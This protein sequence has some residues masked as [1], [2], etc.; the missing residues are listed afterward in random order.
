MLLM[1]GKNIRGGI[2]HVIHQYAKANEKYMKDYDKNEKPSYLKYWNINNLYGWVISQKFPVNDFKWVEDI[3]EFNE[4]FM[5]SYNDDSDE[6]Y[7]LEIDVKYPENLHNFHN[8]LP[9]LRKKIEKVEKLK[10]A[11]SL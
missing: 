1:V 9:F 10:K 4:H 2:C 8:G 5:R 3:S 11:K 6:G 7:F